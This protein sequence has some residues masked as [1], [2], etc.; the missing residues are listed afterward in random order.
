MKRSIILFS[1]AAVLVV[2]GFLNPPGTGAFAFGSWVLACAVF[3][4]AI[5][6]VWSAWYAKKDEFA[7]GWRRTTAMVVVSVLLFISAPGLERRSS[8]ASAV[9]ALFGFC[10]FWF[11]MGDQS[12]RYHRRKM[13]RAKAAAAG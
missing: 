6:D 5:G 2:L 8:S 9:V 1:V 10:L 11:A 12:S 7:E 3:A 4:F 13:A